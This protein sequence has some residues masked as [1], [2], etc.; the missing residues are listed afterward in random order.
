MSL[1]SPELRRRVRLVFRSKRAVASLAV[2]A[3]MFGGSLAAE[4]ITGSKPVV[5]KI[6]DRILF[7]AYVKYNWEDVGQAGAGVV[8]WREI[9]DDFQ[10]AVWPKLGWDPYESDDKLD[11][12]MSAPES[13]HLMGTDTA[14]RDVFARL[15]YGTRVSF[16]FALAVWALTYVVGTILGMMQGFLGGWFDLIGQRLVEIFSSIPEFYLLLL[17]ITML[18]PNVGV[19]I[20]L[21]S[22]F[23]WV[24]ISQYMRAEALRNRGLL[25]SEAARSLGASDVRVL[26][27]HILPNSL[28]PL[29]TFSPFAIVGGVSALAALDL[30]GFGVPPP[31][32]SWGELL[33][34]ARRNYQ[35][36]WWLAVFPSTFLFLTVVCF[37]LVGEALRSAFDPRS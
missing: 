22:I 17:L 10:W 28:I 36:A 30:L 18:S 3:V 4:W 14:G 32:P 35:V 7:P 27:K 15:L 11:Q 29:V 31:T 6:N 9:K 37:N 26:F 34:Q 12:Y 25:Y 13:S 23:G 5:G 20:L 33:D 19:L 2:L 16:A 8:D 1:L 21:S 24:S